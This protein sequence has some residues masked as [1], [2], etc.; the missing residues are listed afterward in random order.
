MGI[1]DDEEEYFSPRR[2]RSEDDFSS[3]LK[4][5]LGDDYE[6]PRKAKKRKRMWADDAIDITTPSPNSKKEKKLKKSS[7]PEEL[8]DENL[9]IVGIVE[10]DDEEEEGECSDSSDD[11]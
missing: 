10:Q 9:R 2:D 7:E 3:L 8:F 5:H 1:S 4:E 6:T 11:E